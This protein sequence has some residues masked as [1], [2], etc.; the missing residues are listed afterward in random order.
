MDIHVCILAAGQST[1]MKSKLSKV[2]HPICGKPMIHYVQDVV[3]DIKPRSVTF[4]VGHQQEQIRAAVDSKHVDFVI[5]EQQMGT[6]HA[7]AQFLNQKPD[8]EG[9]LLVLSGDTPLIRHAVLQKLL[10]GQKQEEAAV[11]LLTA[12]LSQPQGYGRMVRNVQGFLEKIVEEADATEAEKSIREVNAGIYLFELA[13]LRELIPLVQANNRQKEYYLPDVVAVALEKGLRVRPIKADPEEVVGINTR[14]E[15]AAAGR[16]MRARINQSWMKNGVTMHDPDSTFIDAGVQIGTDTVLYPN[17]YLEGSTVIGPEVVIYQNCRI[18]NSRIDAE[19]LVY[20][21]CSID[22]AHLESGVKIGPFARVRP[23][24]H[25]G[26]GVHVGNFVE[27]KKTT[28]AEGSKANHLSYLGDATIGKRVNVG[29]GTITCNYDG[30]KKHPT[31]IGDEVFIGSDTQLIAPVKVGKGAYIAA[32]STITENV[33][34]GAL[35]IARGKQVNKEGW[36]EKKKKK[37]G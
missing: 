1:R 29:A 14:A 33:P 18:Q 20:E 22:S 6:A 27:L 19:C 24:T 32:G 3:S 23:E 4:V 37:K 8:L 11:S 26:K 5:Q 34:P 25:L 13:Q 36:V 21:N 16:I 9:S 28:I 10:D 31:V 2:L 17:V 15:L 30:E 12:D 35:A 7:V